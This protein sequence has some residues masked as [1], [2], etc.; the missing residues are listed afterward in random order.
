MAELEFDSKYCESSPMIFA[1]TISSVAKVDN[2][3][4]NIFIYVFIVYF[5]FLGPH[6]R[7]TEVPRLGV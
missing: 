3:R 4:I 7:H 2:V 1:S 6:P 5:C